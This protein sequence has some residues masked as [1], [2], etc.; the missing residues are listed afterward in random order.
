MALHL[1]INADCNL[2]CV[3]CSAAG[4]NGD[5]QL[6]SLIAMIDEDQTGHVQISGG[7][8][9]LKDPLELLEILLRCRKKKKLIELQTNAL[10]V[11]AYDAKRFRLIAGL[12]DYFNVNLSAHTP[13]LDEAVTGAAGGF[14]KRLDG[15]RRMLSHGA[16]VRLTYVVCQAN[17][18]HCVDF[19]DFVA[20]ELK[21]V[22]WIQFS[23]VKGVGRARGSARIIPRFREAAPHLNEA[24]AF[25][26]DSGIRFEVDHIPVCFVREFEDNHVD[27]RKMLAEQPGA[28][29]AEKQRVADCDGCSLRLWCPGPR[30]D[31][32]ELYGEL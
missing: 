26:R 32:I 27:Y 12:V 13:E 18:R 6:S 15:V 29:L 23:F 19:A 30:K 8:P 17:Y 24:L 4:R 25:C 11:P 22:E 14:E 28:H 16:P 2:R 7:D 20:C 10:L 3:F 31:Y 1:P 9:M 21:G 5:F